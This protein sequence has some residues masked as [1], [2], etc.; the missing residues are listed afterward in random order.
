MAHSGS[1][2]TLDCWWLCFHST[3][4]NRWGSPSDV[5]LFFRGHWCRK[6]WQRHS[7]DHLAQG[8]YWYISQCH[9]TGFFCHLYF[10]NMMCTMFYLSLR[11]Q[12]PRCKPC[13]PPWGQLSPIN[14]GGPRWS[15]LGGKFGSTP[16]CKWV[17]PNG[18]LY[19]AG[20]ETVH[21]LHRLTC[22]RCIRLQLLCV[23]LLFVG[24]IWNLYMTLYR[25]FYHRLNTIALWDRP[26][27]V[28]YPLRE[29]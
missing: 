5:S 25:K 29:K 13:S 15:S 7:A 8:R 22:S 26:W 6:S 4:W 20:I 24:H 28:P 3:S 27:S 19:Q 10:C 21:P 18:C 17:D 2:S 12:H 16:T 14:H 11:W 9:T 23:A 1:H